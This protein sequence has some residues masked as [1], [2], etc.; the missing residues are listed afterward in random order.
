MRHGDE[1][2]KGGDN[3][4]S[5][6]TK[7]GDTCGKPSKTEKVGAAAVAAA[8]AA[9][10]EDEL[11]FVNHRLEEVSDYERKRRERFGQL[12]K[13]AMSIEGSKDLVQLL[14][15]RSEVRLKLGETAAA[16]QDEERAIGITKI[17]E[18]KQKKGS[19]KKK[20]L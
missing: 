17:A 8:Y 15:N 13:K 14:K 11:A 5:G 9:D 18:G 10:G 4:R 20:K 16:A 7:E 19:K 6:S 3:V 1:D 2:L 12:R